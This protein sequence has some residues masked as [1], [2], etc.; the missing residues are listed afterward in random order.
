MIPASRNA[1]GGPTATART[2]NPCASS[3]VAAV[4]SVGDDGVR[5]TTTANAPFTTRRL[6]RLGSATV[7]SDIFVAGS[8]GTKVIRF[9]R[10]ETTVV[11]GG[12]ANGGI[13]GILPAVR[14]ASAASPRTCASS[15]P[16]AGRTAVTVSSLRV[17]VPVLS[18]H[19]T[20]WLPPRPRRRGASAERPGVPETVSPTAAARVKVAGSATGIDARTAVRT[21][22]MISA[23]GMA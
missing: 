7:A 23:S 22:G 2:L 6:P 18:A 21:R 20:S 3:S 4:E 16:G 10:S 17:S 11:H 12:R 9:G 15:K 5:P 1:G 14:A 19:R 13:D 8:N